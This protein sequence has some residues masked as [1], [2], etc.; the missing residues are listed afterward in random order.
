MS[1]GPAIWVTALGLALVNAGLAMAIVAA[2][3]VRSFAPLWLGL[4][5]LLLGVGMAL[6]AVM[7]WRQYL[8]ETRQ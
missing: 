6:A 7:L 4:V 3:G 5:L 8:T 2:M 1:R